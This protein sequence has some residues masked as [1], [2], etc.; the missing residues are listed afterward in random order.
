MAWCYQLDWPQAQT[1]LPQNT[2]VRTLNSPCP[3]FQIFDQIFFADASPISQNEAV[4]KVNFFIIHLV[5]TVCELTFSIIQTPYTQTTLF[6]LHR[7][8]KFVLDRRPQNTFSKN[9]APCVFISLMQTRPFLNNCCLVGVCFLGSAHSSSSLSVSCSHVSPTASNPPHR[10]MAPSIKSIFIGLTNQD[11]PYTS[12]LEMAWNMQMSMNDNPPSTL[13][14]WLYVQRT[15]ICSRRDF[16]TFWKLCVRI[17]R[18]T[19][20]H[21]YYLPI[22]VLIRSNTDG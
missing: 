17:L 16:R 1:C 21:P 14:D 3:Y 20:G 22:S 4:S 2:S 5:R 18:N 8:A 15:R 19:G 10:K 6:C 9:N 11:Q 12:A 13:Y 7:S